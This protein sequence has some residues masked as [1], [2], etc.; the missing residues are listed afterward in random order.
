MRRFVEGCYFL[1]IILF[2]GCGDDNAYQAKVQD[3]IDNRIKY[4][5]YNDQS[6]FQQFDIPFE[7]PSYFPIDPSY[8]V[9]AQ[10]ERF[11]DREYMTIGSSDGSQQRYLKYAWLTFTLQNVPC[12]LLVLKPVGM[13][14]TNIFFLA[15]ADETS[16]QTTYGAGRYLDITIGK[17]DKLVLDFN[18]AYNP[19][20]AYVPEYSC[21]FPPSENV[22]NIA[23]E[24]GEKDFKKE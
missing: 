12:R 23:I 2:T 14:A 19:Y 21:P 6:P 8:R 7:K 24:A 17:S 22:L 16:G 4:L 15:F 5:Q 3:E 10:V 20:C 13:G 9:N 18:L 1:L 11:T